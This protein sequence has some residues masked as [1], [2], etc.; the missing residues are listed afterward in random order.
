MKKFLIFII[1]IIGAYFLFKK[2][3]TTTLPP[4]VSNPDIVVYWGDGCPHCENV[5]KYVNDNNVASKI[6]I[7]Y[8]EVWNDPKNKEQMLSDVKNCPEINV[9]QGIGVPLAF[10]PR[11]KKC[12]GGDVPI[13]DWLKS[14]MLQWIVPHKLKKK[15]YHFTFKTVGRLLIFAVFF[16]FLVNYLSTQKQPIF[17][18]TVLGDENTNSSTIVKDTFDQLY[19][20]LPPNSRKT[21][22]NIGTNPVIIQA[23]KEIEK[24]KQQTD[25]F[26]QKQIK[27]IQKEVVDRLY[28]TILKSIDQN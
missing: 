28:Q 21:L 17:D 18:P 5:K 11:D 10:T 26:P 25:G 7:D 13:I 14:K 19:L 1:L 8:R 3:K 27:Q 24:I 2:T 9:S 15:E 4:P 12:L 16:Y 23:Q 6:K 20:K 22:E